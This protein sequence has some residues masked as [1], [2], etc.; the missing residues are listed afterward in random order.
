MRSYAAAK[1]QREQ[2]PPGPTNYDNREIPLHTADQKANALQAAAAFQARRTEPKRV[3]DAD[4]A[5][6]GLQSLLADTYGEDV[7]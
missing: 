2:K 5:I 3:W 7:A 4:R 1:P 6:T